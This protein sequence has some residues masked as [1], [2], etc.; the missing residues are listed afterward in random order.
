MFS[1]N[2]A[3][4]KIRWTNWA[5]NVKATPDYY[6]LPK[7][8]SDIQ[9]TVN[10]CRI[11]RATLRVTGAAHSFSAVAQPESDAMSLDHLQ[12]LISYDNETMEARLWAGT[13]LYEA[14]PLL[15]SVG[16]AL[17][18][19]GDIQQQTIAGAISTGTHGTGLAFGSLSDQVV[20][21]TWVDGKGDVRHH[22]RADDDLSKA[23]SLSLGMLGVLVDVTIRTVPLYSLQVT[24]YKRSLDGA[25]AE[26][27]TGLR[28][29]RHLEW[30][31]FPGTDTVQVKTTNSIPLVKQSVQSKAVDFVKNGLVETAG[32]KA[33]SE[34]CRIKPEMSRKMTDFS[35]KS[36]PTGSKEGM[37]Y[38]IFP[39]PRLVKFTETEYAIPLQ[40]FEDC[41]MEMHDFLRAHPF[42]VHFPI[43]CRVT[44]GEDAFLS[45][46]QGEAT[47]FLAFHMYKGMDD[48]PYFK[49]VHQL[50]AT[51]GGRPHFGKMNNL[52]GEKMQ[53]LYPNLD[54]FM[55]IREQCD[56][57]GV[58]M[59]NYLQS[60]FVV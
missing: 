49:W 16:M 31:Y 11:R 17:E 47:A 7:S 54:R 5:Q 24:S 60:I 35:A 23:L 51:Y 1:M 28:D 30:F 15:A 48:G 50:M 36:V 52:T 39:S 58:F 29:N 13:Y 55:A 46:T 53:K 2:T 45:P 6:H 19:M 56:P 12:G 38:E 14:A 27:P 34:I 21:W 25:L 41:M 37:Y 22:R 4:K 42:F 57:N 40:R 59:T 8:V 32:F 33:I 3:K 44:A 43:E 20:A 26:W 10:S 9:D 18:N